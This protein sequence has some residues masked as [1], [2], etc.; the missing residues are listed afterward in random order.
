MIRSFRTLP[1]TALENTAFAPRRRRLIS[2]RNLSK[3][4]KK[5]CE[6]AAIH[7]PVMKREVLDLW[8]PARR[9]A[10]VENP[11]L[12]LIDGT[13]GLGGHSL[14]AL[15]S[16]PNVR[17]LAVDRDPY[18][19]KM[20]KR[21]F[22]AQ[23]SRSSDETNR[24][25]HDSKPTSDALVL[26]R[27]SYADISPEFLRRNSFPSKVDGILLDLGMNSYQIENPN[28]GFTFR[29]TGPLDMRFHAKFGS[30]N[31]S[32][33]KARDVV[34]NFSAEELS[35]V[36]RRYADEPHAKVIADA[37]VRW[38]NE[39]E[40]ERS[41]TDSKGIQ[42]T[43][44]LRYII[45]EAVSRHTAEGTRKSEE[46][47]GKLERYRKIW[48]HNPA[49][50]LSPQKRRMKLIPL[51]EKQKVQHADS[52]MRCFQALRIETNDELKHLE[53]F[54]QSN[55]IRD[56]LNVGGRLVMIAFHPGEDRMVRRGMEQLV[57]SGEFRLLTP[58]EEGLRPTEEEVRENSKSRTARLRAVEKVK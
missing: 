7:V 16:R 38:R 44:E 49:G 1:I 8:L 14:A 26:R 41:K 21:R 24:N 31:G 19:V 2:T 11:T 25:Q 3:K 50:A 30:E 29:K 32:A 58:E 23:V 46:E 6:I 15:H 48:R 10:Q 20:A 57:E 17:I 56:V 37:I 22:E 4:C 5:V 28:R 43:L 47:K 54:L 27:G 39:K 40:R 45:E 51:Y 18:A 33:V 42:S 12:H 36:F 53:S 55:A 9:N 52:V 34:N 13:V 35:S